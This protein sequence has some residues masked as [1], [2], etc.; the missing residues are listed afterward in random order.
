VRVLAYSML[1]GLGCI[2]STAKLKRKVRQMLKLYCYAKNI[3]ID[4]QMVLM[5]API[6]LKNTAL[7]MVHFTNP[8]TFLCF[9][10]HTFYF[11]STP[12]QKQ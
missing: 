7:G 6:G 10:P 4:L 1:K 3:K 8:T 12:V 2:P 11:K 9:L 5:Y